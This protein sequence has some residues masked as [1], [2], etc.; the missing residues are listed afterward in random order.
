MS[1][2]GEPARDTRVERVEE[3]LTIP[4]VLAAVVSVPAVFLAMGDGATA[5]LGMVLNWATGAVLVGESII[6][7]ILSGDIREWIRTHKLTLAI[8]CATIPAVIFLVGPV[9]VLRLALTIGALRIFRAGRILRA[10]RVLREKA[11][12]KAWPGRLLLGGA[13]VI[14]AV[15]V[16]VIL[17]DPTSG[18]RQIIEWTFDRFGVVTTTIATVFAA[19][20]LAAATVITLRYRRVPGVPR[21]LARLARRS[22][23][24]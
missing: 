7:L 16:A 18:S 1:S 9:Q 22:T 10:G 11:Q 5:T 21:W 15:F 24:S 20:V 4:V 2:S 23:D 6:L 3:R 8:A 19:L 13:T 14:A 17:A 12:L